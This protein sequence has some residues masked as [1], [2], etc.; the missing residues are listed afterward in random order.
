MCACVWTVGHGGVRLVWFYVCLCGWAGVLSVRICMCA[1]VR[2]YMCVSAYVLTYT[3]EREFVSWRKLL[4]MCVLK[5][6]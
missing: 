1:C 4:C 3:H 5:L 2:A 6:G